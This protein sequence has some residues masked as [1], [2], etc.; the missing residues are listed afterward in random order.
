MDQKNFYIQTSNRH[1]SNAIEETLPEAVKFVSEWEGKSRIQL[2]YESLLL[3]SP[4]GK[5]L[6][7][8]CSDLKNLVTLSNLFETGFG[9]DIVKY[10][11]WERE[12]KYCLFE[13][14][15]DTGKLPFEDNTFDVVTMLMVLEH[16]FDP[17]F[18]ISEIDRVTKKG[19]YLVINVPNIA[20]FKHRFALLFG[21]LPITS[22]PKC[23]DLK[24]W[25]GGH[26]HY[27]TLERL[28]WLLSISGSF[29]VLDV[30]SS[31]K[32]TTLRKSWPSLLSSD[33]Q[34]LSRKF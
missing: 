31:G 11:Q 24:E 18:V 14:N 32:F 22:N 20:Y 13:H 3:N 16:V 1:N 27:F 33:L 12:H 28:T 26:I 6:D 2:A 4:Y 23:W 17:F 34:I 15:L 30:K 29:S 8:G 21:R 19:A 25:D 5:L 9:I 10:P 7:I